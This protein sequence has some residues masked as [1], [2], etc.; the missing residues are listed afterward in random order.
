[1]PKSLKKTKRDGCLPG[2][3]AANAKFDGFIFTRYL[4]RRDKDLDLN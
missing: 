2:L 1:M 3:G 4:E